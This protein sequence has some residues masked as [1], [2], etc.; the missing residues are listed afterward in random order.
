MRDVLFHLDED[1]VKKA[2]AV[3]GEKE[4]ELAGVVREIHF[5]HVHVEGVGGDEDDCEAD[6]DAPAGSLA[7][8][9][10]TAVRLRDR[11]CK[12]LAIASPC[13]ST[14]ARMQS[15]TQSSHRGGGAFSCA[16]FCDLL[17]S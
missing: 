6:D 10:A 8:V 16:S 1:D 13:A 7:P 5:G 11:I 17:T 2:D 9:G 3:L 12:A 14:A 4:G 15:L